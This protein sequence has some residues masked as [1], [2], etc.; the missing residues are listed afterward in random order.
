MFATVHT[1][2]AMAANM[3]TWNSAGRRRATGLLEPSLQLRSF[4]LGKSLWLQGGACSG[5]TMS[6]LNAEEPSACDL[7]TTFGINILWHPSLGIELG[8][9]LQK[10]L[11]DCITGAIPLD[12]LFFRRHRGHGRRRHRR[13]GTASR[14]GRCAMG[15]RAYA[16]R[17]YV[18]A[19]GDCATWGGI[20]PPRRT[21][22]IPEPAVPQRDRG[23]F[24]GTDFKSPGRPGNARRADNI[25]QNVTEPKPALLHQTLRSSFLSGGVWKGVGS[26]Q[27]TNQIP[28]PKTQ[29]PPWSGRIPLGLGH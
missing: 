5:N 19:V 12:I 3:R 11:R 10:I 18:V 7:V 20:P 6:F 27:S 23:G 15:A 29:I 4:A 17:E 26:R 28:N 21:R 14:A 2:P 1:R 24:L 16:R 13:S 22:P 9:N 25:V 8:D